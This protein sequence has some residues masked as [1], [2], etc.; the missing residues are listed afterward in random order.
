[1]NG[2][3]MYVPGGPGGGIPGII[4]YRLKELERDVKSNTSQTC[5]GYA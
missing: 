3:G 5:P 4:G 2:P 1:M